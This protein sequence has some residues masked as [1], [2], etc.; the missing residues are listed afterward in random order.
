M[1]STRTSQSTLLPNP[2]LR[3]GSSLQ[4]LLPS[5]DRSLP[6]GSVWYDKIQRRCDGPTLAWTRPRIRL[7][8]PCARPLRSTKRSRECPVTLPP[9][10]STAYIAC[11][12]PPVAI[13]WP[14]I[15]T[16]VLLVPATPAMKMMRN[17]GET[18]LRTGHT[19]IL[20]A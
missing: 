18:E 4:P 20:L 13:L 2:R 17:V 11:V 9:P 6:R 10:H 14:W 12:T 15:P 7:V 8:T 1:S 3:R 16:R 19:M 5:C